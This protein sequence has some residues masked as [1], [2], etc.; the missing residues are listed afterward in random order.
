MRGS[1]KENKLGFLW[2]SPVFLQ[3]ACWGE[4]VKERLSRH[5]SGPSEGKPVSFPPLRASI[6]LH[7]LSPP[8]AGLRLLPAPPRRSQLSHHLKIPKSHRLELV[9][10]SSA[11]Y[12]ETPGTTSPATVLQSL[13]LP[14]YRQAE[15]HG[16]HWESKG[17]GTWR[18]CFPHTPLPV[19][20][21]FHCWGV[22]LIL[23]TFGCSLK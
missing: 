11:A 7:S 10:P 13:Q 16:Q 12:S 21:A 23:K 3:L 17:K 5:G 15:F 2:A 8:S 1:G 19:C 4:M 9:I 18:L 14:A 22:V 6:G 20:L